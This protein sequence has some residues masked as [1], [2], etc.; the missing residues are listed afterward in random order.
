MIAEND[1]DVAGCKWPVLDCA[2]GSQKEI[3]EEINERE[4]DARQKG[5]PNKDGKE[6]KDAGKENVGAA[7]CS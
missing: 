5:H 2:N 1:S 6:Y 7:E 4:K 3:P